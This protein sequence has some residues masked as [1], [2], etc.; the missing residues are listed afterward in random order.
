[1]ADNDHLE[2]GPRP[3]SS[4]DKS[5]LD[6]LI[7]ARRARR[8]EIRRR[9]VDPYGHRFVRTHRA[10][11]LH[12]RFDELV[13]S[14][15]SVA[16]R[17]LAIRLHGKAAFADLADQSGKIQLHIRQDLVGEENY[18]F[19]AELVEPGDFIGAHGQL[20][21]THRGEDSIE[22][23][24][25]DFLTKALRPLPD[26]WHGLRDVETRYRQRY[27]D[28]MVNPGVREV[29]ITRSRVITSIRRYL[30]ARDFLEVETPVLLPLAGGATAR[31]FKTHHNALDMDLYLRIATELHLKR[32]VVG[33]LERVY[34]IG[35]IFRNEGIST[36]HNPE[37]TSLELYQAYADY[38][39]MMDLT[40]D[41]VSTVAREV[42]G[43]TRVH[44]QGHDI[45]LAPPWRRVTLRDLV[46]EHAGVDIYD[47]DSDDK[48]K[49]LAAARAL[50]MDKPPTVGNVIEELV[51]RYVEPFLIQP[52]F[53]KDYPID[54]SPLARRREDMPRLV[55]RFEAFVAGRELANAFSELNDADDQRQ[56]FLDQL[57]KRRAGD[58]E[59]H[60]LDEDYIQALEYGLCPT[61]GLGIGIDRLVM[62]LTD[63]PSIRDVILFPLLRPR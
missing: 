55:Y 35:R 56:R 5:R 44:Y 51:D 32:L 60:E 24:S 23:K 58:D 41:L 46:L 20:F 19:F 29:F 63:Q 9:G 54:I 50:T 43:T 31:P 6:E 17:L 2:P 25:F 26:K 42:L 8:D 39:D 62:L 36:K 53:I 7:A 1:M 52:V 49:A 10:T 38:E 61:G 33:G 22:V 27:L 21:R 12:A 11:D 48:A 16:G 18:R 59:A 37:F 13:G 4:E 57:A 15:V 45:E 40:E 14:D 30:D 34:E 3:E 28:L 47:L